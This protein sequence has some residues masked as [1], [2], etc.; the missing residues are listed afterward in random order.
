M[1][2]SISIL[3]FTSCNKKIEKQVKK[4]EKL[5]KEITKE[6]K[7]VEKLENEI[8]NEIG[9]AVVDCLNQP[10]WFPH[11]QTP[12]PLEGKNGTKSPFNNNITVTNLDFHKWSWQKFLWLTKPASSTDNTPLF[13][14]NNSFVQIDETMV[15]LPVPNGAKVALI[16]DE[17]A[18]SNGVLKT[19]SQYNTSKNTAETILY[20]LHTNTTMLNTAH[21]F[22]KGL[23]NGTIS[24]TNYK[25]FPIGSLEMKVS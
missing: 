10:S 12:P 21:K 4:I 7:E 17:Q 20:S 3:T 11:S 5:E 9:S 14:R 22:I 23:K 8:Y 15:K 1:L 24:K 19:N 13:L 25:T 2:I 16:Y 18:C 6:V